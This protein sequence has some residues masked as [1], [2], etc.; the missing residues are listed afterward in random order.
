MQF[1]N[2]DLDCSLN[3]SSEVIPS[4]YLAMTIRDISD[5]N[6]VLGVIQLMMRSN[7]FKFME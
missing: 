4:T 3:V 7:G 5:N 1:F 2:S 6:K